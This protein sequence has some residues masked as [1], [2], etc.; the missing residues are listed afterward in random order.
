MESVT[1]SHCTAQDSLEFVVIVLPQPPE[2]R[3]QRLASPRPWRWRP[4]SAT[5]GVAL[6]RSPPCRPSALAYGGPPP[7]PAMWRDLAST[8]GWRK[9]GPVPWDSRREPSGTPSSSLE[10][11]LSAELTNAGRHG[12][13][14]LLEGMFQKPQLSSSTEVSPEGPWDGCAVLLEGSVL[15]GVADSCPP[16][17]RLSPDPASPGCQGARS[18]EALVQDSRRGGP[19]ESR[20]LHPTPRLPAAVGTLDWPL[21]GRA[22]PGGASPRP[23]RCERPGCPHVPV[24]GLRRWPQ[25]W[26]PAASGLA[27]GLLP[28]VQPVSPGSLTCWPGATLR[29]PDAREPVRWEEAYWTATPGTQ[30][31]ASCCPGHSGSHWCHAWGN[32]GRGPGEVANGPCWVQVGREAEHRHHQGASSP[33]HGAAGGGLSSGARRPDGARCHEATVSPGCLP[34]R[35]LQRLGTG[36]VRTDLVLSRP[37]ECG[38]PG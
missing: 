35:Q 36:T 1:G 5:A 11:S 24:L 37:Q 4:L 28:C 14:S 29:Q 6:P 7:H 33:G 22:N 8:L 16:A 34:S 13:T 32:G 10:L 3:D 31:P 17:V 21:Q 23:R 18:H 19:R 27:R 20:P 38:R 12:V 15:C 25:P 26:A 30:V 2:G 9:G